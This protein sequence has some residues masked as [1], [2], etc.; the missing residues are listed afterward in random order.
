MPDWHDTPPSARLR[1]LAM[2]PA[3][4]AS[5]GKPVSIT[6][7]CNELSRIAA[8]VDALEKMK[9]CTCKGARADE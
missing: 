6:E 2:R 8:D 4:A 3:L 9:A 1:A 7:L 5:G